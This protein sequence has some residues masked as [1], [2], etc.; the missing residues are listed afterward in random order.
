MSS[1]PKAQ[2]STPKVHFRNAASA[3][4][5]TDQE[6]EGILAKGSATTTALSIHTAKKRPGFGIPVPYMRVR[7]SPAV[8]AFPQMHA[9]AVEVSDPALDRSDESAVAINPKNPRNIVAG[10]AS[11]DGAQ[12]TNMAYVTK[13]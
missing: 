11:F 2:S 5:P 3:K 9:R 10:A 7:P 8:R 4:R 12:F 1:T 13:D 6:I